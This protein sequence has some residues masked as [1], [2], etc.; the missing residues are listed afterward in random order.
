MLFKYEIYHFQ[1]TNIFFKY[2]N[3]CLIYV[4]E[5]KQA[6]RQFIKH[7]ANEKVNRH[8]ARNRKRQAYACVRSESNNVDVCE[9]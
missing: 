9:E 1:Y 3:V 7:A 2:L 6:T 8:G 5:Y 4:A